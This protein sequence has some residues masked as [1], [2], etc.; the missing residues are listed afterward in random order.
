MAS[1]FSIFDLKETWNQFCDPWIYISWSGRT[2]FLKFQN[3][4][5]YSLLWD[6]L[7]YISDYWMERLRD[8]LMKCCVEKMKEKGPNQKVSAWSRNGA[9]ANNIDC[10]ITKQNNYLYLIPPKLEF[11]PKKKQMTTEL[12]KNSSNSHRNSLILCV[13]SVSPIKIFKNS[14]R[15]KTDDHGIIQKLSSDSHRNSCQ[16]RWLRLMIRLTYHQDL[17]NKSVAQK[18]SEPSTK[19]IYWG[20]KPR[21][22]TTIFELKPSWR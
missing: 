10:L 18:C 3:F 9:M 6:P 12:F 7:L 5:N 17:L 11:R 4:K 20:S 22:G 13:F 14:G 1:S 8:F 19:S 15:K 21:L 2:S 16:S